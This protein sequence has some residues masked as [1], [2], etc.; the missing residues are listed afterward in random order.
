VLLALISLT[1]FYFQKVT[2]TPRCPDACIQVG[3]LLMVK[4]TGD[5]GRSMVSARTL[6][7]LELRLLESNQSM[8]RYPDRIL[9]WLNNNL[10]LNDL[11]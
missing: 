4:T 7:A 1:D 11:T 3:L 6:T 5:Y 9:E 8:L 10:V 2:R